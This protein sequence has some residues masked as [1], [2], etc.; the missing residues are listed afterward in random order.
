MLLK[1]AASITRA[2]GRGFGPGNRDFFGPVNWHRARRVPFG[3]QKS[4]LI[5]KTLSW[6]LP[7]IRPQHS[8][9]LHGI[10]EIYKFYGYEYIC[11]RFGSLL[12]NVAYDPPPIS[13]ETKFLVPDWEITSTLAKDCRNG[14]PGY[15]L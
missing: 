1:R 6:L 15:I 9:S 12:S 14:P 10:F 7:R 11:H 3:T 2:S 4:T 8:L 5:L 13:A